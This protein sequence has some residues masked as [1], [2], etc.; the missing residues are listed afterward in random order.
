MATFVLVPGAGGMAWYWHRVVPLIRRSGHE[1]ILI[2]LPGDDRHAG[3]AVYADI[4]VDAIAKRSEI[5]LVAQ[6]QADEAPSCA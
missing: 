3:L 4:I 1:A 6:W 5:V 2:D